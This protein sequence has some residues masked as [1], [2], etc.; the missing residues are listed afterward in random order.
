MVR[1]ERVK[2]R[3]GAKEEPT[4]TTRG[5]ELVNRSGIEESNKVEN[6]TFVRT[7]EEAAS[8]EPSAPVTRP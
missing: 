7:P 1:I 3:A 8:S 6:S 4:Q 5:Y 2:P